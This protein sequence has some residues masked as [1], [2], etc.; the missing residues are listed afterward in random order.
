MSSK[1]TWGRKLTKKP[2][3]IDDLVVGYGSSDVLRVVSLEV[4]KNEAVALVGPNGA[5]KSTLLRAISGLVPPRSGNIRLFGADISTLPSWEIAQSGVA[6]TPQGR[7]CFGALSVEENLLMGAYRFPMTKARSRLSLI[8]DVFPVLREKRNQMSAEL[9][10]GQQQMVAIGRSVMAEPRL[11]LLDEPSLGLSPVLVGEMS[12]LLG[13][14]REVFGTAFLLAEQNTR[15]ALKVTDRV[16]VLRTG[17][18]TL[19][20]QSEGMFDAVRDAY[21]G[22]VE[23]T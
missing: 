3:Q 6:H 21:F 20:G 15:L 11:L 22:H 13:N 7:M 2:L 4:G 9:S 1:F 14:I 16:Y 12:K 17:T 18:I 19:Q 10:G 5:G 23:Q 8:Y